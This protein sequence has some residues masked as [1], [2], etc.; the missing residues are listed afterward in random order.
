MSDDQTRRNLCHSTNTKEAEL[1]ADR[2]VS[3]LPSITC[4]KTVV[5]IVHEF[6]YAKLQPQAEYAESKSKQNSVTKSA[7]KVQFSRNKTEGFIIIAPNCRCSHLRYSARPKERQSWTRL[8]RRLKH[9]L[10][11]SNNSPYHDKTIRNHI[12][13]PKIQ[14]LNRIILN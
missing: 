11:V 5:R 12:C 3:Q 13:D 8:A 9:I 10:S 4:A 1:V 7:H 14:G 2:S 6:I